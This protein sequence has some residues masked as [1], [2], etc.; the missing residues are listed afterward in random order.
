MCAQWRDETGNAINSFSVY[1]HFVSFSLVVGLLFRENSQNATPAERNER[2][3]L[4]QTGPK[5]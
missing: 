4:N 5:A 3:F 1:L 2:T